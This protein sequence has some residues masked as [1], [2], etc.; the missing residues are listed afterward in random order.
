M[1]SERV[2]DLLFSMRKEGVKIWAENGKLRYQASRKSLRTG[3]LESLKALRDDIRAFLA[4]HHPNRMESVP[5]PRPPSDRAPVSFPQQYLWNLLDL[6]NKPSMRWVAAAIRL[7]GSLDIGFLRQGFQTLIHRHEALRTRI[8]VFDGVPEQYVD[9][10]GEYTLDSLDLT[11]LPLR[12]R[13]LDARRLVEQVVNEPIFVGVGPLFAARLLK[14][15]HCCHVLVVATDHLISDGAS[16]GII[17]R[18][19][20]TLYSQSVR[21][22]FHSLPGIAVQYPDYA[23]WQQKTNHFWMQKHQAYW[24]RRLAGTRRLHL[25]EQKET[26]SVSEMKWARLPIK[27]GKTLSNDLLKIS[28]R[29]RTSLVMSVFTAFVALISRWCNVADL[30]LPFGTGGRAYPEVDNTVGYFGTAIFLRIELLEGDTFLDLLSRVTQ[31]Y[32]T[33]YDHNDSYRMLVHMRG[34]EFTLNPLFNWIPHEFNM[35][36]TCSNN[37]L[38]LH[39]SLTIDPFDFAITPRDDQNLDNEPRLDIS[40]SKDGVIGTIGYR[41]DRFAPNSVERFAQSLVL[42]AQKMAREPAS[43]VKAVEL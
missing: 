41:A 8:V 2:R 3:D 26:A 6:E 38:Q 15:D 1:N 23:A 40:D 32:A 42:F 18:D 9:K 39:D 11:S 25:F 17:W 34:P 27:F 29:G 21:G 22:Q 20:L 24:V 35:N 4:Q 14:L 31:E 7:S 12:A 28:R 33:A 43:R 36:A 37:L 10:A 19:L 5:T 13:E 30:I 16:L